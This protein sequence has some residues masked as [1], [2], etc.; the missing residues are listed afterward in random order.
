MREGIKEMPDLEFKLGGHEKF[1][2]LCALY[3]TGS[4]SE[5]ELQALREHLETCHGCR[6]QLAEYRQLNRAVMP[7]LTKHGEQE[8]ALLARWEQEEAK[9]AKDRLLEALDTSAGTDADNELGPVI[10]EAMPHAR[11]AGV[12]SR[13]PAPVPVV[14]FLGVVVIALTG[15]ASYFAGFHRG[16][17]R[18]AETELRVGPNQGSRLSDVLAEQKGLDSKVRERDSKIESLSTKVTEQSGEIRRL[19]ELL[20]RTSGDAEQSR[21]ALSE[22]QTQGARSAADRAVLE[23]QLRDAQS[24][25]VAL[26][27]QLDRTLEERASALLQT[28]SLQRRIDDLSATLGD[29]ES[30]IQEQQTLLSSDRDIRELMG[31]R[32]LFI[33]DVFDIDRDGKTK[34]PFG[35]VFYTKNKSLVFYAFDLGKQRGVRN[36]EDVAF[37]AWGLNDA[38]KRHP[39]NLGVFYMDNELN[40]RWALKFDNPAVLEKINAVFVTVEPSGGSAKPSGKQLLYAYLEAQPNHP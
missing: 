27:G 14:A 39:L 2:E 10:V 36:E 38:D 29:K 3:P 35:R 40:R 31:A 15:G 37:Q 11:D 32:N 24:A 9:E 34:K 17:E 20:G 26:R 28:T 23:A 25:M 13:L 18:A 33:A 4:L 30:Q 1:L 6:T 8:H 19:A 7:T 12:F 5:P 22:A 21:S 16:N